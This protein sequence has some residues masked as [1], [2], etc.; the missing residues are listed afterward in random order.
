[1]TEMRSEFSE[2][3]SIG[4]KGQVKRI[5]GKWPMGLLEREGAGEGR[6]TCVPG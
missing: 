4:R 6:L 5:M 2:R 1:M 3:V